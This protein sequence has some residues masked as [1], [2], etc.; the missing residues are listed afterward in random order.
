M[1]AKV[2]INLD[3]DALNLWLAAIRNS[4]SLSSASGP[5]LIELVPLAISLLSDNLDLLGKIVSIIES[6]LF[7]DAPAVLQ[8]LFFF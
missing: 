3:E 1:E 5:G 6:Y 8:V 2:A 7:V 4:S